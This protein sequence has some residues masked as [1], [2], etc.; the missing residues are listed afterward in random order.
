MTFWILL[1]IGFACLAG[2]FYRAAERAEQRV[3]LAEA[4]IRWLEFELR[5]LR[6]RR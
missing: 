5:Q 1:T 4:R 6:V 2:T 3:R